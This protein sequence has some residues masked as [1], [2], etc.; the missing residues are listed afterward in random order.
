MQFTN[1]V[2]ADNNDEHAKTI[3]FI[4]RIS[5]EIHVK[6]EDQ[7]RIISDMDDNDKVLSINSTIDDV[8]NKI[9]LRV[10]Q[11]KLNAFENY[12]S[13]LCRNDKLLPYNPD[14]YADTASTEH[15]RIQILN[16]SIIGE[17]NKIFDSNHEL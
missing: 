9:N 6:I 3:D 10:E 14:Q 13:S 2:N 7:I 4:K 1:Q 16:N 15:E 8:F 12:V 5:Q 17:I 11:L